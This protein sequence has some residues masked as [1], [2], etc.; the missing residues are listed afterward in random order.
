[1]CLRS[2]AVTVVS[3]DKEQGENGEAS[4]SW[5]HPLISLADKSTPSDAG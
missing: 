5:F 2:S 1:M 3:S 4:R